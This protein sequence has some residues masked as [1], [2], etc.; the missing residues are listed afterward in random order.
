MGTGTESTNIGEKSADRCCPGFITDSQWWKSATTFARARWKHFVVPS[1]VLAASNLLAVGSDALL[2]SGM[3]GDEVD[4]VKLAICGISAL[5]GCFAALGLAFW[6]LYAWFVKLVAFCGEWFSL[7]SG[8]TTSLEEFADTFGKQKSFVSA[9][10]LWSSFYLLVPAIPL[11]VLIA[12]NM[13]C[14]PRFMVL[15]QRVLDLPPSTITVVNVMIALLSGLI[16]AYTLVFI[17]LAGVADDKSAKSVSHRTLQVLLRNTSAVAVVSLA[18]AL[19]NVL[20][21]APQL[22]LLCTPIAEQLSSNLTANLMAQLWLGVSSV[23]IWPLSLLPFCQIVKSRLS[24][25]NIENVI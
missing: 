16:V 2:T 20:L 1:A 7:E 15:G 11:S 5:A 24:S 12:V 9:L 6:A 10:M 25:S 17:A 23:V 13:L 21:T 18:V 8:E 14:S 19:I 4:L 3:K 22:I